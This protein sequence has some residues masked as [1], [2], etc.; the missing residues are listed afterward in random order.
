[1][2]EV[3]EA[4]GI[5]G[6]SLY[7]AFGTCV[8]REG[9]EPLWQT[10]FVRKIAAAQNYPCFFAEILERPLANP[11]HKRRMPINATF[12]A[13]LHDKEVREAMAAMLGL[14]E[15][16]FL[17]PRKEACRLYGSILPVWLRDHGP[18]RL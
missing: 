13:S 14:V 2:K 5:T 18:R 15:T 6:A 11:E 7:D 16:S 17:T 12:E 1:M 10:A 8:L 4:A 3:G 9:L